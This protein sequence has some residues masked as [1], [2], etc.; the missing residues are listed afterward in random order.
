MDRLEAMSVFVAVVE[1]GSLAAAARK[2]GCSPATVTRAI[3]HLETGAGERLLARTTRRFVITE[4]GARHL[5]T[6]RAVLE[7]MADLEQRSRDVEVSGGVVVTA[8]ELFGRLK[9]LPVV[10]SFLAAHPG[11]QIRLLLL[12]RVVDLIGEG[13]DVAV[14]LADLPDSSMTAIRIGEVRKL[15]CAAPAYLARHAPPQSPSDLADHACIGLNEA[16]SKELWRYREPTATRRARSVQLTCRL[17]VNGVGAAIEAA[18]RGMGIVRPL[19]YQVERQ[20]AEG[21]LVALLPDYEPPPI[22]V[23]LVFRPRMRD[24][25]AV[26]AFIDYAVPLLRPAT[27]GQR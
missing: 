2:L 22:P 21:A 8:P 11:T 20:I 23:H 26:R 7:Q 19:S 1:A 16:G 10:E 9:V 6:Y 12:N 18:E 13:V 17:A 5:A 25:S 15:T 14:R 3:A 24:G 4:T 27:S